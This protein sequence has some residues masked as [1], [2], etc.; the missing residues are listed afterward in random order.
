MAKFD[1]DGIFVNVYYISIL[2]KYWEYN[3]IKTKY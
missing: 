2:V 3:N 1:I